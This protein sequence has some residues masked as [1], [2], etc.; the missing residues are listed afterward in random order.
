MSSVPA[1]F[2]KVNHY[3]ENEMVLAQLTFHMLA[4]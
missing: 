1:K 2:E 4:S 3:V